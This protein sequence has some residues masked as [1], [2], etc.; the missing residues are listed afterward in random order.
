LIELV[1]ITSGL[2]KLD[3]PNGSTTRSRLPPISVVR[4]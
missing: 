4:E 1:E 2:D 3:H